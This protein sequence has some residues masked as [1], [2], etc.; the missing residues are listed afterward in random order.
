LP[1]L[2]P[3]GS[4][5]RQ[6]AAPLEAMMNQSEK[7]PA[8]ESEELFVKGLP[9]GSTNESVK[10][11]FS[12][13]G[14]VYSAA[15]LPVSAGKMAMAAFVNMSTVEDARNVV[16]SVS[17][18][19]PGGLSE[20]V[21]VS[22][23]TPRGQRPG[24]ARNPMSQMM[25]MMKGGPYGKGADVAESD[26]CFVK[27]LPLHSNIDSVKGIFTQYGA[28]KSVKVLQP[29]KGL[30]VVA[31][32]VEMSSPEEA[33]WL[34]ENVN[35]QTPTGLQNPVEISL[36]SPNKQMYGGKGGGGGGGGDGKGMMMAMMG[37]MQMMKGKMGGKGMGKGGMGMGG[38]KG[39]MD[40]G[41]GGYGPVRGW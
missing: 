17:G 37:M 26:T 28:V 21:D 33:K 7:Q 15:V 8:P 39:G 32:F 16:Q 25:Q 31:A 11:L 18:Q 23:A 41:M 2:F 3:L 10:A 14:N 12:Q 30:E 22:Y 6:L 1:F 36:A 29:S 35:G 38:G 9:L 20:P 34:V 27:S 4:H 19:I 40:M 24:D 5:C 13:Y